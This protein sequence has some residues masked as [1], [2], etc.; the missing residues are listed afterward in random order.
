MFALWGM[1][2]CFATLESNTEVTSTVFP[3]ILRNTLV[4]AT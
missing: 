3:S 4:L 2:E 1:K